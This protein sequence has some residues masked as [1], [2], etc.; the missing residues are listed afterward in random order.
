MVNPCIRLGIR[1]TVGLVIHIYFSKTLIQAGHIILLI[2]EKR[3]RCEIYVNN[4]QFR[5]IKI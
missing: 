3:E 4:M 5:I 1:D 2:L